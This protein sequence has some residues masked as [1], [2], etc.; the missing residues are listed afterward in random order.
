[1]IHGDAHA[2]NLLVDGGALA[3]VIDWIDLAVGD[4]AVDLAIGWSLPPRRAR[5][6]F[7]AAYGPVSAATWARA[8]VNA[9]ARHGLAMIAAGTGTGDA[10]VAAHGRAVVARALVD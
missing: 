7:L 5:A 1:M 6:D 4:P 2:G 8:R 9:V 3:A 10:G